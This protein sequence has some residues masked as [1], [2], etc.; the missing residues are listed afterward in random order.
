[1]SLD[2]SLPFIT[3]SY[4]IH[5]LIEIMIPQ[6]I[7]KINHIFLHSLLIPLIAQNAVLSS[8]QIHAY[9]QI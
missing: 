2:L 3:L 8:S 9:G 7:Q 6:S 1:M 5:T 4:G